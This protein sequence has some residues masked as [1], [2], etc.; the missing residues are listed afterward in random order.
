M[1]NS[2]QILEPSF[3]MDEFFTGG[4]DGLIGAIERGSLDV[5]PHLI[6]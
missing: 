6:W 2:L 4:R 3:I 5:I 1:I